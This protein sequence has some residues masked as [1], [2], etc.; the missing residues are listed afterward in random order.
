[1]SCNCA[2]KEQIDALYKKYGE[3]RRIKKTDTFKVKAKKVFTTIGVMICMIPI[4]PA[5]VLFVIY[6]AFFDD[7]K[8][9]S[10]T[11]FFRLDKQKVRYVRKQQ[12]I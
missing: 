8:R 4:F 5:L 12:V 7:D 9:I 11:K 10:M 1:M 2:T 6:K 3:R